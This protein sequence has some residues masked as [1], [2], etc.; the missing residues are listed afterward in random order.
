MSA[1][2]K[3]VQNEMS[4]LEILYRRIARSEARSV[5]KE[6][7]AELPP[8]IASTEPEKPLTAPQLA[9]ILDVSHSEIYRLARECKIPSHRIGGLVK[10]F[11]SEVKAATLTRPKLKKVS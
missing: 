2:P 10:F 11:L 9:Q 8:V 1:N 5:F 4:D 6:M 3:P 7:L